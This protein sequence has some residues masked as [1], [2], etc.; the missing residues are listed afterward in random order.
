M[1]CVLKHKQRKFWIQ[2][3]S[4]TR[5]YKVRGGEWKGEWFQKSSIF[6][7]H[8]ENVKSGSIKKAESVRY[9]TQY[10]PTSIRSIPIWDHEPLWSHKRIMIHMYHFISHFGDGEVAIAWWGCLGGHYIFNL[11]TP[12]SLTQ[13]RND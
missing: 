10:V 9:C 6:F 1:V 8:W 12:R 5:P 11:A 2:N 13:F 7:F 3:L 4:N